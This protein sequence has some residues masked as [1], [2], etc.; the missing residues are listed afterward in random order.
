MSTISVTLA[1]CVMTVLSVSGIYA[2]TK[3][4]K[5]PTA[6]IQTELLKNSHNIESK[7]LDEEVLENLK[8][9]SSTSY[10][11]EKAMY[12]HLFGLNLYYE[13]QYEAAINQLTIA[14]NIAP[15]NSTILVRLGD[16]YEQVGMH[17]KA[18]EFRKKAIQVNS[19]IPVKLARK[20]QAKEPA[21]DD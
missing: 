17:Q 11:L 12:H 9:D 5:V 18:T 20:Q 2:Q 14:N 6:S 3:S 15:N 16:L 19:N 10:L 13:G 8:L 1:L 7:V 4:E 21:N